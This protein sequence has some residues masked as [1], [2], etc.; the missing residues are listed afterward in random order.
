MD[1]FIN[2][3]LNNEEELV[4]VFRRH[5]TRYFLTPLIS[6]VVIIADFFL[7]S[8]W[9]SQGTWGLVAFLVILVVFVYILIRRIYVRKRYVM[10]LTSKRIIHC[11][12]K[13]FFS[14]T[15]RECFFEKIEE[16]S[17]N[18]KGFLATVF[19]YGNLDVR[20]ASESTGLIID[21]IKRP[22]AVKEQ[23]IKLQDNRTESVVELV[24]DEEETEQSEVEE[25]NENIEKEANPDSKIDWGNF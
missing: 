23:I 21:R 16:I 11:M 6:A 9:M 4:A 5:W 17:Y 13:G 22:G 2:K 7:L 1:S 14:K 15:Q 19:N 25:V 3:K 24:E 20:T 12:Q 8:W 18:K 10:I